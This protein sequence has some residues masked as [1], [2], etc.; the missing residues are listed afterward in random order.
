MGPALGRAGG[1][2]L[3]RYERRAAAGIAKLRP[4]RSSRKFS[5]RVVGP[6]LWPDLDGVRHVAGDGATALRTA[7]DQ[8][9]HEAPTARALP[10]LS[11]NLDQ[12]ANCGRST[13]AAKR[14]LVCDPRLR[15]SIE[16]YNR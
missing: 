3:L 7:R 6:S 15:L 5:G 12:L 11:V 2:H 9:L 16:G 10:Y 8:K 13:T 4:P 14:L 1:E